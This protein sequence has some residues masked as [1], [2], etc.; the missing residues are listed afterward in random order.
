M[1]KKIRRTGVVKRRESGKEYE[2]QRV[3][4]SYEKVVERIS[5]V[6]ESEGYRH[7]TVRDYMSYWR[8]FF[9]IIKKEN[10]FDVTKEDFRRYITTLLDVRKLSPVTVNIRLVSVKAI[11]SKLVKE[12]LLSSNPGE[13]I[14]KLKIDEKKI[15]ALS[16]SQIKRLFSMV[17]TDSVAGYRDYCAMLTALYCGL[18]SNELNALEIEDVDFDNK[19]ILL[20]GAKNKNRK[21]RM[22]PMTEKVRN[23]LHQLVTENIENFGRDVKHVFVNSFGESIRHDL[24]RK[25]MNMYGK[26]SG[27]DKEGVRCSPHSLRHSFA[28]RFLR[29]G[30][31][32][33]TLQTIMGHSEISTTQVYLRYTDEDLFDRYQEAS[34]RNPL[35]I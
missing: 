29:G 12:E 33:R 26:K 34:K 32:I 21:T 23:E 19:V 18:R 31:D 3:N 10:V 13:E 16:D 17:D 11:F 9:E 28:V 6:Y 4:L 15:Y 35:D 2:V 27:L 8:E 1:R 24:I 7:R 5:K 20:P 22:I 30:G 14:P 25:R